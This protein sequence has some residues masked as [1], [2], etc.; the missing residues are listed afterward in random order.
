MLISSVLS[1]PKWFVIGI[2][3]ILAGIPISFL[4]HKY[5]YPNEKT[6]DEF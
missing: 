6:M 3:V 1:D 5:L 4:S 2:I